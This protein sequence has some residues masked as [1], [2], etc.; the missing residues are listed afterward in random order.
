MCI[1]C[2]HAVCALFAFCL[3]GV[4]ALV[5][6]RGRHML[7]PGGCCR[8]C[9]PTRRLAPVCPLLLERCEC[10]CFAP[11]HAAE[12]F[13]C[14]LPDIRRA[15]PVKVSKTTLLSLLLLATGSPVSV[16]PATRLYYGTSIAV[17]DLGHTL[18]EGG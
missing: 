11:L 10:D 3:V 1:C 5:L 14:S 8:C 15:R 9:V 6:M 7:Y 13:L 12:L 18:Q 17:C 16:S 2:V 4:D